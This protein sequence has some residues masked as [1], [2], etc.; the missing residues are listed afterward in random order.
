MFLN[1]QIPKDFTDALPKEKVSCA[2]EVHDE[3]LQVSSHC[4]D[5]NLNIR[6]T[7][8]GRAAIKASD[9]KLLT[10]SR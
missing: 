8:L 1:M 2:L 4:Q 10:N 9:V 6:A 3:L 5:T 7:N